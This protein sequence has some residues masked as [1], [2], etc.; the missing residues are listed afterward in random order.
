ME[1]HERAPLFKRVMDALILLG[2]LLLSIVL[3]CQDVGGV[4][5]ILIM[6]VGVVG[7]VIILCYIPFAVRRFRDL[8][9]RG[10]PLAI[11]GDDLKVYS[12][13]HRDYTSIPWNEIESFRTVSTST[14]GYILPV[15]KD[16]ERNKGLLRRTSLGKDCILLD[17][18]EISRTD[19]MEALES[20][21][22]N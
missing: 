20:H 17:N 4:V 5:G 19:L 16:A 12:M 1:I 21:L 6:A 2:G 8:D 14:G 7:G 10:K 13:F 9:R 3:L 22:V 11:L 15:Y 18:L